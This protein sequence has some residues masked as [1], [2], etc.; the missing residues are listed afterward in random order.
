MPDDPMALHVAGRTADG[1]LWH[2][3][4]RPSGWLPF[5]D[6]LAASG[7]GALTSEV[8]DVA[9]A[10]RH[11]IGTTLEEGLYVFVAFSQERPPDVSRSQ[12]SCV[13]ASSSAATGYTG[14]HSTTT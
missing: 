3:I 14:T 4:R 2:T 11:Q 13:A 1:R 7:L 6:V 8:V 12:Y 10:R 9:C 5:G